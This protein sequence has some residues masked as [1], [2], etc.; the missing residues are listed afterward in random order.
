MEL[1][2]SI[3]RY[4]AR[5]CITHAQLIALLILI[6]GAASCTSITLRP[7]DVRP[8]VLRD[9]PAQRLAYRFE[10]DVPIPEGIKNEAT[11]DKIEAI[12]IDFNTRREN[13]ALMKTVR[14]PDGYRALVLYNSADESSQ[15]FRIDLYSSDGNFVRNLTPPDLSCVFPEAVAWSPDGNTITFIAHK[16][17]KPTPTPTPSDSPPPALLEPAPLPT[18]GPAFPPVQVFNTEQI[19]ICN[20]DGYDL[21]PLTSREG[22][23]YF[24]ASWAADSHA[25]VALA[26]RESEW[27]ARERDY[28]LPVG[29]PRLISVDGTERL[30]DDELTEALPVWSSDSSK[31]ATAFDTDVKIYDAATNKPTQAVIKLHDALLAGSRSYEEKASGQP[32]PENGGSPS[33]VSPAAI[34]ASFNPIVRLEWPTPENLYVQTAYVRLIPNEPITTFQRWHLLILSAQAALLK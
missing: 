31:V 10:P 11:D 27:E 9:V 2:F 26:C 8:R 34:P 22:L 23:I 32:K 18:V 21:K 19:Y 29:R 7:D 1:D 20:R 24:Y 6:A 14:S 25:L 13:D 28:K 17:V 16:N 4:R 15:T 5:F 12:Q 30:L 3:R 33:P